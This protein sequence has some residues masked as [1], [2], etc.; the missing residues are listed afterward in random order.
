MKRIKCKPTKDA[1]VP[2]INI[3]FLM[4]VF[5]VVAGT[6]AQPLD[7]DLRLIETRELDGREPP[8]ALVLNAEGTLSFRGDTIEDVPAYL[9]A[10]PDIDP[11][12]VKIV[13]DKN[14]D[15]GR[16][17]QVARALRSA[18]AESVIIVTERALQ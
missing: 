11:A 4:L 6:V 9:E 13:P 2:L 7:P 10:R 17:L 16:L 3:V 1:S 15:G 12:V 18:G 8:D 14:A 5:F